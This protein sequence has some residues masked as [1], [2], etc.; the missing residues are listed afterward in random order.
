MVFAQCIFCSLWLSN[1]KHNWA[2]TA[3]A[4]H[5]K[6]STDYIEHLEPYS[7]KSK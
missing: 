7:F 3:I 4:V 1:Y 6:L 2:Y 5:V